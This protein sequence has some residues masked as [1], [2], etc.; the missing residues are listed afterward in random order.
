MLRVMGEG[1]TGTRDDVPFSE[2]PYLGGDL[3]RGYVFERFRDRVSGLASVEYMW[4]VS[5][6]IDTYLF[7]DVGRVFPGLDELTIDQP[8][9]GYGL[10]FVLRGT[11][12]FLVE[13]SIASTIDG[14]LILTA[15]FNPVFDQRTRWR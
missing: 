3:L 14:G 8:R 2:L 7:V 1:V 10:G 13:G 5:R 4:D 11:S 9:V 15:S 12:D 6:Y